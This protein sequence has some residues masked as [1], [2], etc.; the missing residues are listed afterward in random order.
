MNT[1]SETLIEEAIQNQRPGG[2]EITGKELGTNVEKEVEEKTTELRK[3]F[4][5]SVDDIIG[6]IDDDVKGYKQT[7][8]EL[9]GDHYVGD[10]A[11]EGAAGYNDKGDGNK[12]VLSEEA[13]E[14]HVEDPDY[15]KRVRLHEEQHQNEQTFNV[16][17]Q[18]V[19][20]VDA[21]GSLKKASVVGNLTER[22]A[23]RASDQPDED[24]VPEYVEHAEIGD[25]VADIAGEQEVSQA[26]KSGDITALQRRIFEVQREQILQ[27]LQQEKMQ[28]ASALAA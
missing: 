2:K 17:R 22:D 5:D 26:L 3:Q 1:A 28:P 7:L 23:I 27:L 11:S 6:D 24:L 10:T 18:E 20:Y 13:A 14:L 4:G 16:N 12:V 25:E 21:S 15:W 9:V 19:Q 8:D